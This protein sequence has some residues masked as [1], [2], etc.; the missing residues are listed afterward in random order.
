MRRARWT[1]LSGRRIH[2]SADRLKAPRRRIDATQH[3]V[4]LVQET[5][6]F[7]PGSDAFHA[8]WDE[9]GT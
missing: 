7:D 2:A 8:V 1:Q 9:C 3:G 5:N 6:E 4:N